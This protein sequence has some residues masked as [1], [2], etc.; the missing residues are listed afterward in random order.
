MKIANQ[1]FAF[2]IYN[3]KQEIVE[4][5]NP[6][7]FQLYPEM[8]RHTISEPESQIFRL[9]LR[10]FRSRSTYFNSFSSDQLKTLPAQELEKFKKKTKLLLKKKYNPKSS[11]LFQNILGAVNG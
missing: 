4:K 10:Y 6:E 8:Y 2:T 7:K 11:R 9:E 1:G 3:K 5:A